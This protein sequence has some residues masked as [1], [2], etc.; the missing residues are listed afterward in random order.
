MCPFHSLF[1]ESEEARQIFSIP[2]MRCLLV[3]SASPESVDRVAR[4]CRRVRLNMAGDD[5]FEQTLVPSLHLACLSIEFR[6]AAMIQEDIG[7]AYLADAVRN[8]RSYKK[9]AEE[10]LAQTR[11]E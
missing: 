4:R 3:L 1:C 7:A 5:N 10:A 2:F 11:D 8:F 6:E 9:L